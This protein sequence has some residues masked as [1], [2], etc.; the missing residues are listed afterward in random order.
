MVVSKLNMPSNHQAKG[1]KCSKLPEDLSVINNIVEEKGLI[2]E[3]IKALI[4]DYVLNVA[5]LDAQIH[6]I[7]RLMSLVSSSEDE[8]NVFKD[9]NGVKGLA[10]IVTFWFFKLP[11]SSCLKPVI[12]SAL[13]SYENIESDTYRIFFSS[14]TEYVINVMGDATKIPINCVCSDSGIL[15][16]DILKN[17]CFKNFTSCLNRCL[18]NNCRLSISIIRGNSQNIVRELEKNCFT[19]LVNYMTDQEGKLDLFEDQEFVDV[20]SGAIR[21]TLS[22]QSLYR[23]PLSET[24]LSTVFNVLKCLNI[25]AKVMKIGLDTETESNLTLLMVNEAKICHPEQYIELILQKANHKINDL[26]SV[27]DND[28]SI[29]YTIQ[30]ANALAVVSK[31]EHLFVNEQNKTVKRTKFEDIYEIL[32]KYDSH[33]LGPRLAVIHTMATY[34]LITRLQKYLIT[35]FRTNNCNTFDGAIA[36]LPK[37]EAYIWTFLEHSTDKVKHNARNILNVIVKIYRESMKSRKELHQLLAR[38][39]RMPWEQKTKYLVL[40]SIFKCP[41]GQI[42]ASCNAANDVTTLC[43]NMS[44]ILIEQ[45]QYVHPSIESYC[46]DLYEILLTNDFIRHSRETLGTKQKRQTDIKCKDHAIWFNTWFGQIFSMKSA[47]FDKI[48]VPVLEKVVN[49][50][51]KLSNI[52]FQKLL[53]HYQEIDKRYATNGDRA[54]IL[55]LSLIVLKKRKLDTPKNHALEEH[56]FRVTDRIIKAALYHFNEE[57]RIKGIAK[58]LQKYLINLT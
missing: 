55:K 25:K 23:A 34:N 12:A 38:C 20:F 4:D 10:D 32:E 13:N 8:K 53:E 57:I 45:F 50:G 39:L 19:P 51:M 17:Q 46:A 24:F 30:I 16:S 40:I 18:E 3:D 44:S 33:K 58:E 11:S 22:L 5:T 54:S 2:S 21:T 49:S 15:P 26:S 7:R 1:A 27:P 29:S 6:G 41:A 47:N 14:F 36:I 35:E 28:H 9:E 56:E 37:I 48:S 31:L 42:S 52:V 43:P